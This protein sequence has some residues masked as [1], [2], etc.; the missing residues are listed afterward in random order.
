MEKVYFVS[1]ILSV[2]FVFASLV[3]LSV[4]SRKSRIDWSAQLMW[5]SYCIVWIF[6]CC[7]KGKI[8]LVSPQVEHWLTISFNCLLAITMYPTF[9][10]GWQ[11]HKAEKAAQEPLRVPNR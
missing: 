4:A 3:R 2:L 5:V 9:K 7:V 8:I 11:Q 10:Q 1:A 6:Y